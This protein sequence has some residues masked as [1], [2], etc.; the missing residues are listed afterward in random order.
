M[1]LIQLSLLFIG[2]GALFMLLA[3]IKTR[4]LLN[5]L[6]EKTKISSWR[7]LF[8][9]ML[10]FLVGYIGSFILILA[11][12]REILILLTGLVFLSGALFVYIVARVSAVTINDL[13]AKDKTVELNNELKENERRLQQK[14]DALELVNKELENERK[15]LEKK[16]EQRTS[17]LTISN[18][19]L[20]K[21]AEENKKARLELAE[22]KDRLQKQNQALHHIVS[23]TINPDNENFTEQLHEITETASHTIDVD[24]VSV[25][26]Y[27]ELQTM[28]RC[29]DLFENSKKN[30]SSGLILHAND[31]PK[32]FEAIKL[33]RV[34][35]SANAH[36]DPQTSEFSAN[37]LTPFGINS[38]LDA[39]IRKHG[40]MIGIICFEHTDP[41]R[42]W[43]ID[44]QLFAGAMA[45]S[46]SNL[47]ESAEKI[48]AEKAVRE[49]EQQLSSIYDTVAD[50][51][52][53]LSIE[54]NGQY[55]FASINKA[56]EKITGLTY[57]QVIGKNIDEI[58]PKESLNLVL[59]NYKKAIEEKKIVKW[60][61]VSEY[62]S[63][64]IIG[65]V[66]VAAILD[67]NGESHSVVGAVHDI[68]DRKNAENLIRTL[69]EEL[70][71]RVKER[72]LALIKVKESL[73]ISE[74]KYRKIVEEAGDAVYST[75][76][77]GYFTYVNPVCTRLTG[78][79][80][81]ELIGKHFLDLIA[82]EWKDKVAK[83][84]HE[85]A[86]NKIPETLFEFIILTKSGE[87]KWVE[88]IVTQQ[89]NDDRI[90]GHHAIVRDITQRKKNEE[91]IKQKSIALELS[92]K[93]L[94]QFVHIASHDLQ[95]PLRMVISYL[96]LIEKRYKDKLDKDGEDFINFAVEG[97]NRMKSL[98]TGLLDYSHVN[99]VSPYE[100]IDI[101]ELIKHVVEDLNGEIKRNNVVI[102]IEPLPSVFGDKVLIRQ[103][104]QHLLSNAIKFKSDK[105][106][107]IF[108]TGKTIN[109][110]YLFSVKDNGIGIQKE[111]I[112]K[113]F[114]I[115]YRLNSRINYPGTGIGLAICKKIVEKHGGK[116][117]VESEF[118]KGSTF[119]FT[120]KAKEEKGY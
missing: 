21:E 63:G 60:E 43:K 9:L 120:L 45:D 28:I 52:F 67:S 87:Q 20:K 75:D 40:K 11:G 65:E 58:I 107:E 38:M 115:L 42:D 51:I 37:Y 22:N 79:L 29:L 32:Y 119:Y 34:I 24:R 69:N 61:E 50:A 95:E 91:E 12:A 10:F 116:I 7:I 57:N 103:L 56:F 71:E 15:Q 44:E 17:E 3:T 76:E 53:R 101:N 74:E 92:S 72:T 23:E 47:F 109:K 31:Y 66:S 84:Y 19:E 39:P 18:L 105:N 5:Q 70:E 16:I 68:T 117:W 110:D 35:N 55:K 82:P 46:I 106:A 81:T 78:Y 73:L 2:I 118:G 104:F 113:L 26:V 36:T 33:N 112:D 114:N 102:A 77:K 8:F 27:D 93:E 90:T 89:K 49:K 41:A 64:K 6:K 97:S 25:W 80:E 83:F 111:Y 86:V 99:V 30:H 62:P 85:Q 98:I 59:D 48:N 54:N 14:N 108:I 13:I 96:Q 88:Q 1:E 94:Q 100:E 4:R